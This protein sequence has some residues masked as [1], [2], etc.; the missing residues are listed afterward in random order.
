MTA[1]VWCCHVAGFL[2]CPKI[3]S[4]T[5]RSKN[6][7]KTINIPVNIHTRHSVLIV[8]SM[9][10]NCIVYLDPLEGF[11]DEIISKKLQF[12]RN[13]IFLNTGKN[14]NCDNWTVQDASASSESFSTQN[15]SEVC[16]SLCHL[17][18]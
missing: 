16:M 12:L 11:D 7:T 15:D 17:V 2:K 10:K 14:M 8:L 6:G 5:K 13:Q 3:S 9:K 1:T 4:Q 18:A